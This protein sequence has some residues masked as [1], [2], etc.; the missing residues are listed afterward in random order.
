M[1][2]DGVDDHVILNLPTNCMGNPE[3][4]SQGLTICS[5]L[6][7]ISCTGTNGDLLF[8]TCETLNSRGIA[9]KCNEEPNDTLFYAVK[10]SF[11]VFIVSN[12]AY[13]RNEWLLFCG[14]WDPISNDLKGYVN[15]EQWG[16]DIIAP[17]KT[18]IDPGRMVLG[19][20]YF[21]DLPSARPG[22][23]RIDELVVIEKALDAA[24]V[25]AMYTSYND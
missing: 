10:F 21:D 1:Y 24:S 5:W 17:N 16:Y 2:F 18:D 8:G 11:N 25:I 20:A 19:D 3:S 9:L 7:I 15:G 23:M 14:V 12:M 13:N 6:Y 22:H 4:C